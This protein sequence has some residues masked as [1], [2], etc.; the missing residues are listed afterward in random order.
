V[1]EGSGNILTPVLHPVTENFAYFSADK[2]AHYTVDTEYRILNWLIKLTGADVEVFHILQSPEIMF[3]ST[4]GNA[5]W[6]A[7]WS[8]IYS[9]VL[10]GKG[11]NGGN[12]ANGSTNNTY[13]IGG[14]GGGGGGSGAMGYKKIFLNAGKK[15]NINPVTTSGGNTQVTDGL[16]INFFVQNGYNGANATN[17]IGAAGGARGLTG[18]GIDIYNNR[19][20]TGG[21]N[22][23]NGTTNSSAA[24]PGGPGGAGAAGFWSLGGT[25]GTANTVGQ[26]PPAPS[27]GSGGGGGGGA[28]QP[29]SSTPSTASGAGGSGGPGFVRI[30]M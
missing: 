16:S 17:N 5:T 15:L 14:G 23:T 7:P 8:K 30:I 2:N 29:N 4:G 22:G 12:G 26:S 25:A 6:I 3:L 11:G 18:G 28:T 24:G 10:Q 19:L 9:F 27:Y 13:R 20:S 1:L 21:A